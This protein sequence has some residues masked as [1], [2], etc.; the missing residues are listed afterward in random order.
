MEPLAERPTRGLR[1]ELAPMVVEG[2][3]QATYIALGCTDPGLRRTHACVAADIAESLAGAGADIRVAVM[4]ALGKWRRFWSVPGAGLSAEA[5]AGLF[6]ELWFMERWMGLPHGFERW[7]PIGARH[8]FRWPAASVEVK[9]TTVQWQGPA[10]HHIASLDQLAAPETGR[11]FL[12][13]LQIVG[14]SLA[15]NTLP[16]LVDRVRSGV[17]TVPG[18]ADLFMDRLAGA[19]YSPAEADRYATPWRIVTEELYAVDGAFPRLT[20]DSFPG[21]LPVGVD[22]VSYSLSL[23]G[24]RAWLVATK[25]IDEPAKVMRAQGV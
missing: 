7:A 2:A 22:E 3:P 18:L 9:T 8:D 11:L 16:G 21:G 13:S 19:G 10:T 15:A 17:E 1:V 24:C 20:R 5:A 23:A 12:F 14:D 6:G 4:R 25:P